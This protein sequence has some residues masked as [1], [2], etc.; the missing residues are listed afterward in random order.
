[1]SQPARS[2]RFKVGASLIVLLGALTG[3][4]LAARAAAPM[5]PAYEAGADAARVLLNPHPTRL[6]YT[7]PGVKESAGF[8]ATINALGMRGDL[9][10]TPKPADVPRVLVLGDSSLFGHGVADDETLAEQLEGAL[11][12]RG[13]HAEV[14]NGGTPGYSTEQTRLFLDEVGWDLAPDLLVVAN[15]WS[16]NNYDWFRD[17]DLLHTRSLFG[18]ALGHSALFRLG[19]GWIDRA[20]GGRGAR[21]VSWTE[22]DQAATAV[23]RRVPLSR[24]AQNLAAITDDARARGVGVVFLALTNRVRLAG[25]SPTASWMPYFAAQLEVARWYGLTVLD[26]HLAFR[27]SGLSADRLFVDAMHPSGSG[28]QLIARAAAKWLAATGWP[29]ENRLVPREAPFPGTAVVDDQEMGTPS[30]RSPQEL[31]FER[32]APG[33]PGS[34]G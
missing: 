9:P 14:L 28:F 7:A 21:V 20:R 11:L 5:I 24:Y 27:T 1:M 30:P 16:D 26:A 15:L 29:G 3:L 25:D 22:T 34:P 8:T 17:E 10:V 13:V 31:L 33:S 2:T 12:A 4:E 18:G 19:A 23:G 6:W 32:S